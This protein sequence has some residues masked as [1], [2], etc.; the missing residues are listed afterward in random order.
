V[1]PGRRF[2]RCAQ[3]LKLEEP[4]GHEEPVEIPRIAADHLPLGNM[5]KHEAGK[6]EIEW[7]SDYRRIRSIV[8]M[9][10]RV[11]KLR[12][13]L[14]SPDHHL[15]ADIHRVDFTEELRQCA[16]YPAGSRSRFRGLPFPWDLYRGRYPA[17]H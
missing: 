17:G 13:S 14:A 12:H 3:D 6:C 9:D 5:L 1:N 7:Q 4:S 11:G 10:E 16:R 15:A 2:L 8:L